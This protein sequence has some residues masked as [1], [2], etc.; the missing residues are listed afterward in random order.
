[1]VTLYIEVVPGMPCVPV[2]VD[3]T[4]GALAEFS[5]LFDR[6]VENVRTL[7]NRLDAIAGAATDT[8]PD[9]DV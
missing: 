1:M 4:Q 9:D 5:A 7:E 8:N 2:Q 6:L 3:P